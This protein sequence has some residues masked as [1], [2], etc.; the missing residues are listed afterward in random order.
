MKQVRVT[1]KMDL[2]V[3]VDNKGRLDEEALKEAVVQY[4]EEQLEDD[5]L[6]YSV[7]ITDNE[8]EEPSE[9]EADE[10]ED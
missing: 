3:D 10:Y 7:K 4:L 2:E 6:D 8:D 1:I 5:S 9:L